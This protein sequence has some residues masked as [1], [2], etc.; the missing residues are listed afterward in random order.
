LGVG[1]RKAE[2]ADFNLVVLGDKQVGRFDVS[3]DDVRGVDEVHGAEGGVQNLDHHVVSEFIRATE[4][5]EKLLEVFG[6][7]VKHEE[8]LILGV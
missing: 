1:S 4:F 3:V 2:V 8:D 5:G 6:G 7:I